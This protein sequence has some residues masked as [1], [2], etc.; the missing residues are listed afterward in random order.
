LSLAD[1]S[2]Q[3]CFYDTYGLWGWLE[4]CCCPPLLQKTDTC[5]PPTSNDWAAMVLALPH[6]TSYQPD[7]DIY[8]VLIQQPTYD[9]YILLGAAL[10]ILV[11]NRDIALCLTTSSP[12]C[13]NMADPRFI[14]YSSPT[15]CQLFAGCYNSGC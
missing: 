10:S 11:Q 1:S 5:D 4:T 3:T 6:H 2:T 8:K 15:L 12:C 14:A 13:S 9:D 7:V